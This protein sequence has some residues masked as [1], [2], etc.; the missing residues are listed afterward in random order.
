MTQKL[1][2]QSSGEFRVEVLQQRIQAA[3]LSEYRA[4][5]LNHR[6]WALVREVLLH[7]NG[8][9]WVYARTIIPLS[10]LKGYLRHL[11]FL[12]NRPL[13][14]ALFKDPTMQRNNLQ[15]AAIKPEHLPRNARKLQPAWGRRSTFRLR[16]KSLLVA[17]I[18][19]QDLLKA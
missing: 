10:T 12:G 4:L 1:V 13:G 16:G 15:L 3:R 8:K 9:P 14:E 17:E 19:L 11:H 5:T 7:G 6:R 2:D 18:F